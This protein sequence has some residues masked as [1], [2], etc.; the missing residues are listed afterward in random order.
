MKWGKI[1]LDRFW[2]CVL[3]IILI[4][5]P[6]ASSSCSCDKTETINESPISF[7]A[8]KATKLVSQTIG[9]GGGTI[10]VDKPG[11]PLNGLSIEVP[12][13]AYDSAI[14]FTISEREILNFEAQEKVVALSPLISIDNENKVAE[15][16]IKVKLPVSV[17][18][19]YTTMAFFYD[20]D[21]KDFEGLPT[22][23]DD[24]SLTFVTTHF[25]D[26]ACLGAPTVDLDKIVGSTAFSNEDLW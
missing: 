17:P 16:L 14:S 19:G 18:N 22:F 3:V 20:E 23:A 8:G 21:T 5:I 26:I 2:L 7:D 25:S 9:I 24:K 1:H 11:N 10:T 12:Q 15:K 6:L 4:S 13:G